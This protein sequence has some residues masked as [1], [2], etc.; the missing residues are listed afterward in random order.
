MKKYF[1]FIALAFCLQTNAQDSSKIVYPLVISFESHCC[2]VPSDSVIRKFI[3]AYKKQQKIKSLTA[4]RIGPMGREGEYYLAF[5]LGEI[6]K[7]KQQDFITRI[8]QLKPLTTDRGSF[9]FREKME[10]DASS[11]S[12]RTKQKTVVF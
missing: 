7:K 11:L 6:K 9:S 10:I 8:S 1:L 4:V 12:Q 5:R 2:D 3:N